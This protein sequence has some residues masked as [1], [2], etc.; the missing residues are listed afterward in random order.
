MPE[1]LAG[2]PAR[3]R[4]HA[5]TGDE[6]A[7]DDSQTR[8]PLRAVAEAPVPGDNPELYAPEGSS[9]AGLWSG[10]WPKLAAIGLAFAIWELV[11]LS[12]WRPDYVL[13]G[14]GAVLMRLWTDLLSGDIIVAA[15]ITMKRA[16]LGYGIALVAGVTIGLLMARVRVLRTAAGSLLT[17]LQTMP[18]VA[19]FPLAILLFQLSEAAILAVV[20]LGAAPSIATGLLNSFDQVPPLL[21]RA[22]RVMGARGLGLYRHII[23]PAALPGFLTGLKQGWAFAW[24]SL[25][26]GELLVIIGHAPSIG[27]R[28]QFSRELSDAEGLL[29]WMIVV[30]VL[31]VLIDGLVFGTLERSIHRRR[32]LTGLHA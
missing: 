19:W 27:V 29:A 1:T 28:L 25:M 15:A 3:A 24:R 14:P 8:G 21:V 4:L 20:V 7:E 23:L 10:L 18:S 5:V 13:P 22:G 32:G 26:A 31:G 6:P 2:P 12:G 9:L 30:M 11:V 17:G 16:L